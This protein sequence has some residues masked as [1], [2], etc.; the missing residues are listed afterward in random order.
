MVKNKNFKL[1]NFRSIDPKACYCC[2]YCFVND[3][4][5]NC[6]LGFISSD[7]NDVNSL[8]FGS[9]DILDGAQFF[10]VCDYFKEIRE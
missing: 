6:K 4:S 2:E 1:K 9:T 7:E 8:E 10:H 5:W 3:N